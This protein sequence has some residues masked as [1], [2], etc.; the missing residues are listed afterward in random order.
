MGAVLSLF[1]FASIAFAAAPSLSVS[2]GN[3][4]YAPITVGGSGFAAGEQVQVL[5]GLSNTTATANAQGAF[6]GAALTIPNVPSGLYIVIGIGQTSGQV[7]F[8]YLYVQSLYPQVSPSSWYMAPGSMLSWS[9]SGFAPNEPITVKRD[10]ET[11]ASFAAD[12]NGAFTNAGASTV[13]FSLHG[14]TNAY[15]IKGGNTGAS[16]SMSLS[17][18][19]LYPYVS[20][21]AWYILPGNMVTFTGGGFGLN[22]PVSVYLG[23]DDEAVA[24][25]IADASGSFMGQAQVTIPY[26]TGLA[27]Y[28]VV[29]DLSEAAAEAP[30]TRANF[31][32]SLNP[33]SYYSAPGMQITLAGS[34]FAPDEDVVV[35]VEGDEVGTAHTN[36]LGSFSGLM[37]KVPTTPN[38]LATISATGE[39]SGS[40]PSFDMAIG[41][42]YS[43]INLSTWYEKGGMPLTITGHN[44]LPGEEVVAKSGSQELGSGTADS[45]GDVT[46]AARVPYAPSGPAQI[47]ATGETS[48]APGTATMTVAPVYTDLQ[49]ASY[50]GAPGTAVT[51][52][53]HGYVGGDTIAVTTDRSGSAIVATFT[54]DSTGSFNNSS[55][56]I[57]DDY[58]EG[59]LVLTVSG[60]NSY[61]TKTITYYVTPAPA[62]AAASLRSFS[63]PAPQE[64]VVEDNA[65]NAPEDVPA[66]TPAAELP[67]APAEADVPAAPEEPAAD[68][69]APADETTA[70]AEEETGVPAAEAPATENPVPQQ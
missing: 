11:I 18:A 45:M 66:E 49:L 16:M 4:A 56:V 14:G 65:G 34:G 39:K 58:A 19:D 12:A 44:Y 53:G 17:V 2:G 23:D 30:I 59:E 32:S 25:G 69:E 7:A 62:P 1:A 63:A 70:P 55:F 20:P 68:T 51:F 52:V 64:P 67:A 29:G 10:G 50:A 15:V 21:S 43:W 60:Q 31:Y 35:E 38:S 57:P 8:S 6:S 46:I 5:L 33:S 27:E 3:T 22:E 40:N 42:Y 26:G 13:P 28:R 54:A 36:A 41:A 9:G 47:V 37:V 24:H 61:D 48:G